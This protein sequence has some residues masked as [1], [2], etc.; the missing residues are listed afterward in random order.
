[1]TS[2]Y[3][4]YFYP[5]D[6]DATVPYVAPSSVRALSPGGDGTVSRAGGWGATAT[7]ASLGFA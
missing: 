2:A 7:L 4:R 6:V 1:M 5:G 3:H